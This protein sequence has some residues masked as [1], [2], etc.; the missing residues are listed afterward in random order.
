VNSGSRTF[1]A[2]VVRLV[3]P[4]V[5][6]T[7]EQ[8]LLGRL[9]VEV[10]GRPAALDLDDLLA[11][12]DRMALTETAWRTARGWYRGTSPELEALGWLGEYRVARRL[13]GLLRV[14][15]SA[16][17]LAQEGGWREW[18]VPSCTGALLV[19]ALQLAGMC[20]RVR[21]DAPTA[22]QGRATHRWE[23]A[24][25]LRR[26]RRPSAEWLAVAGGGVNDLLRCEEA[27]SFPVAFL[28][29]RLPPRRIQV[30]LAFG[31]SV[32]RDRRVSHGWTAR[33]AE[34]LESGSAVSA[35]VGR[36]LSLAQVAAALAR[37]ALRASL[38]DLELALEAGCSALAWFRSGGLGVLTPDDALPIT[39]I[40]VATAGACGRPAVVV[41]HGAIIARE[42]GNHRVAGNSLTWGPTFSAVL[43]AEMGARHHPW[44]M[45]FPTRLPA[46]RRDPRRDKVLFLGTAGHAITLAVHPQHQFRLL[47]VLT[48]RLAAFGRPVDLVIRPHHSDD[49]GLRVPD[50]GAAVHV[51]IDRSGTLSQAL[52]GVA[53][54]VTTI[55]TGIVEG[56]LSGV[57]VVACPEAVTELIAG[58]RGI[59]GVYWAETAS[60]AADAACRVLQRA[61]L[62]DS[63]PAAAVPY[64]T[65]FVGWR[66]LRQHLAGLSAAFS[67]PAAVPHAR[68]LVRLMEAV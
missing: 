54:M 35:D 60:E 17:K 6:R 49:A 28:R 19:S 47:S 41:Q 44:V 45:G 52:R 50:A 26:P 4:A 33:L 53:V 36:R 39:R 57:P 32:L 14:L 29:E 5:H 12:D 9:L 25:L 64:V 40:V 38:G 11:L 16:G 46:R 66:Q 62:E 1:P 23:P 13:L 51:R 3:A 10:P 63:S 55:S 42:D 27:R 18:D 67:D 59:P 8:V 43:R 30:R 2:G 68:T 56:A 22:S 7:P 20:P 21:P 65:E 31:Y 48:E 37:S 24:A 34:V 58:M 61:P 15:A